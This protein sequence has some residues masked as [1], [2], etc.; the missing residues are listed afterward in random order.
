[1]STLTAWDSRH[2]A[3]IV[4]WADIA[5]FS[6]R[7]EKTHYAISPA[8]ESGEKQALQALFQPGQSD[9][10]VVVLH[11]AVDREKY[12]LPR[13][14]WFGTLT[15]RQEHVLYVADPTLALAADLQIGWYVGT[16]S[17][18]VTGRVVRLALMIQA[19]LGLARILFLGGSAGGF[20]ALMAS[21]RVPGSR[22]LAFNPQITI[23]EYHPRFVRRFLELALPRFDGFDA[24]RTALPGRLSVLD[25]Y[26]STTRMNNRAL[27]VQNSRDDFHLDNHLS[28]LAR[29][30]SL[31]MESTISE[32]GA[33]E[34]DIRRFGDGHAMP[35]RHVLTR[36]LDL[37]LGR[38][39]E[40]RVV[41]D[42]DIV[43]LD[44]EGV[45]APGDADASAPSPA[46]TVSPRNAAEA[47]T[48]AAQ[49]LNKLVARK[50]V[51]GRRR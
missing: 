43:E 20:A 23:A 18:D 4:R 17:A 45:N 36:Y 3:P 47:T 19:R 41:M 31:P 49:D 9:T 13:F 10:L 25:A 35:Y 16:E 11:G 12:T 5:L 40:D 1:M 37:S 14:E 26:P 29:H 8:P 30:L 27:I 44:D 15:D 48:E 32:D 42:R 51:P 50:D 21:A 33:M 22:A 28:H 6:P 38:W 34:F 24:A 46:D 39:D 7:P 2:E